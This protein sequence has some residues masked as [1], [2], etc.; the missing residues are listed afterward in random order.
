MSVCLLLDSNLK[1]MTY[2]KI[3]CSKVTWHGE[4]DLPALLTKGD[5]SNLDL[6]YPTVANPSSTHH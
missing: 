4:Q 2:A 1:G 5:D 3:T 6:K